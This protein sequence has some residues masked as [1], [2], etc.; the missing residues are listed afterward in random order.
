[1]NTLVAFSPLIALAALICLVLGVAGSPMRRPVRVALIL[2]LLIVAA[3]AILFVLG[4][5]RVAGTGYN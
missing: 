1:M 2:A 4:M 3:L 5:A